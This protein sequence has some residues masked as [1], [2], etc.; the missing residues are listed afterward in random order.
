MKKIQHS[1]PDKRDD[2][3]KAEYDFDYRKAKPN[4][5]AAQNEIR[6]L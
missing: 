4:R 6:D 3:M 1:K 5:F 2:D